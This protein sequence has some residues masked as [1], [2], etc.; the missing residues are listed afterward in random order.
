MDAAHGRLHGPGTDILLRKGLKVCIDRIEQNRKGFY[1]RHH[2]TWLM[3]RSCTRSA[4]VLLAAT[5]CAELQKYMPIAW[6]E[7]VLHVTR[8]L[9]FWKDETRD[10]G[11]MLNIV[12]TLLGSRAS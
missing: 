2:G 7:S 3:L 6:E 5:R 11:E 8:M 10:V 1:H 4:L 12:E 9:R